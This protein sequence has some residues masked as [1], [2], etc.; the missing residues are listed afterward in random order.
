MIWGCQHV[1]VYHECI[2]ISL[3]LSPHRRWL[4]LLLWLR[5]PNSAM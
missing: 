5:P 1:R 4:L 2:T 3:S